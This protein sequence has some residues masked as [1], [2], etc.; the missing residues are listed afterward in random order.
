MRQNEISLYFSVYVLS[1]SL[2]F[3]RFRQ[4]CRTWISPI[5]LIQV[6]E[7]CTGCGKTRRVSVKAKQKTGIKQ[8]SNAIKSKERDKT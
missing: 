8:E 1:L 5:M 7:S 2:S 6:S 4:A 3:S